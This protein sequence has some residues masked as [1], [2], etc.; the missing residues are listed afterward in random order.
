MFQVNQAYAALVSV[1]GGELGF[2]GD[3]GWLFGIISAGLVGIVIIGGIKRIAH[4]AEVIVPFM[5]GLYVTA[6]LAVIVMNYTEIPG[7]FSIIFESGLSLKAGVGGLL[8]AII[9]GIQRAAF[10]NEAGLG[11]AAIAHAPTK[12]SQPISEGFIGMLGPVIDTVIVCT[13]TA[14]VIVTSGVYE[15][16]QGMEGVALTNRAFATH[17]AWFPYVLA[18][19][20]NLF[21][22]STMLAWSYY[23]SKSFSFIFG[24]RRDIELIYRLSFCGFLVIGAMA[25]L[26][27]VIAFTDAMVFAMAVPNIIGLYLLAPTLKRKLKIYWAEYAGT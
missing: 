22:F 5:G 16:G 9:M 10:S 12:T 19:A 20:V 3:K 25:E 6:A 27:P 26:G 13:M 14:L 7:A 4:V 1:T 11:T 18:V 23:G 21:A 24:E 17:I 15:V 2:W 8:G